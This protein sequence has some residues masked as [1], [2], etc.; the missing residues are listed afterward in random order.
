MMI[1]QNIHLESFFFFFTKNGTIWNTQY[2]IFLVF[3]DILTV[4]KKL[5]FLH[6]ALS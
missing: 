3:L 2:K 4:P 6:L 1:G 5:L